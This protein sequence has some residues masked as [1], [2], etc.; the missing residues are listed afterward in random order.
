MPT[1]NRRVATYL[2]KEVDDRLEAFKA[3]RGIEGDSQALIIILSE[4]LGVAQQVAHQVDYQSNFATRDEMEALNLKVAYLA[5]QIQSCDQ[6]LDQV[7]NRT[8]SE[9]KSVLLDNLPKQK[10]ELEV[11]PGQLD[12]L[13]E[14]PESAHAESSSL[15]SSIPSELLSGLSSRAIERRF[16]Q[17]Q[18]ISRNTIDSHRSQPDFIE[19][20]AAHDPEGIAWEYRDKKYYPIQN[21]T[22][23]SPSEP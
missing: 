7:V 22:S 10:E 19:W 3:D 18:S 21:A 16:K 20:S 4:F 9:L 1:R 14:E 5:E 6:R 23:D 17:K 12:L 11:S 8:T 2:P 15:L 13:K